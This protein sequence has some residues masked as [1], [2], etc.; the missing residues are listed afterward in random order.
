MRNVD[1]IYPFCCRLAELWAQYCP[2]WRFTQLIDNIRC[3]YQSDL[4]YVED[5][6]ALE[7]IE[8]YFK[9]TFPNK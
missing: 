6:R 7:L 9:K 5:E 8:D 2:D 4:F 3:Y 1:R